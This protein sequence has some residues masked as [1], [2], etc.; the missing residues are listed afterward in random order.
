MSNSENKKISII[1]WAIIIAIPLVI[2]IAASELALCLLLPEI[3]ILTKIIKPTS[4]PRGYVL[5]ENTKIRY[6]GL[7]EK[8]DPIIWEINQQG[9]RSD[10]IEN[11]TSGNFR[12]LTYGD[13]ET[14]G[15]SVNIQ[16]S[17]Q[18][19]MEKIDPNIE[20]LNFGIPGYNVENVTDHMQLTIADY[21]PDMLIYFFNKNDFYPAFNFNPFLSRSYA[22]LALRMGIY[23]LFKEK[24][25]AW[26]KSNEGESFLQAQIARMVELSDQYN[27]PLY[28]LVMHWQYAKPIQIIA[29]SKKNTIKIIN[30]EEIV[31]RFTTIDAHLTK[32]THSALAQ[33]L[34]K[35]IS[36]ESIK[37]CIPHSFE[38]SIQ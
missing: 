17:W 37:K 32:Q 27:A 36:Q 31:N 4:D 20:V 16:D 5:K 18:R 21:H 19:Q 33:Y 13:S 11:K 23:Q 38:H 34:C 28:I 29:E 35:Q 3:N 10:R 22:Y 6:Q 30:I 7:Y 24:R 15:W 25:K 8:H 12:L 1:G 2:L 26:R 9:L 14:Y